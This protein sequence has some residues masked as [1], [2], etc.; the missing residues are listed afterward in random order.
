MFSFK[1]LFLRLTVLSFRKADSYIAIVY[2][3]YVEHNKILH[4]LSKKKKYWLKCCLHVPMLPLLFTVMMLKIFNFTAGNTC[5]GTVGNI[6]SLSRS[7]LE[8]CNA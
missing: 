4:F 1:S 2:C 7:T 3:P 8:K 5:F 6:F